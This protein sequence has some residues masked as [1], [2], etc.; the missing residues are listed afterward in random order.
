MTY[1]EDSSIQGRVK[2]IEIKV[3]RVRATLANKKWDALYIAKAEAFAWITAGGDSIITR[4]VENGVIGILITKN[5]RYAL[6]DS[7]EYPRVIDEE[8]LNELGFEVLSRPWYEDTTLDTITKIITKDGVLAADISIP[9]A[10]DASAEISKMQYSLLDNEIARYLHLGDVFSKCIEEV[11]CEVK[12]GDVEIDIVGRVNNAIWKHNIDAVLYLVAADERIYKYRHCI[13][14][15]KKVDKFLMICCN[16]RYKGL[17]TKLTRFIH[18]GDIDENLLKQYNQTLEIENRMIKATT[19]GADNLD[20]FEV[21][22]NSYE[23]FGYK[24]MWK[25]HH[26]GGPQG[27]TNGYYL[28]TPNKHETVVENQCYCYNPSITGTKTEDA[29][30][31]TKD[32]PIMITEPK[33]FPKIKATIGNKEIVR[34]GIMVL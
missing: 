16:G 29:F 21:A 28:I 34:P 30:I 19:I 7:I 17:I 18:F 4:Y 23:E 31:V 15:N 13:P 8:K 9:G 24:D 10:H 14:T 32:G 2:E 25:V 20:A 22:K 33:L 11:L 5:A 1:K 6:T 12:P 26:Q 3:E 27:Y